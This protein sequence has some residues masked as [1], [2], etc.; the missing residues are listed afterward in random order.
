MEIFSKGFPRE[1]SLDGM[2]YPGNFNAQKSHF[3]LE[4]IEHVLRDLSSRA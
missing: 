1:V 2:S 3:G 4:N